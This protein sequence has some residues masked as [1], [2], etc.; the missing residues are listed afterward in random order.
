MAKVARID[1]MLALIPDAGDAGW[2]GTAASDL[3]LRYGLAH[4]VLE[5]V[6]RAAE[7]GD[8]PGMR[9]ALRLRSSQDSLRPIGTAAGPVL[10]AHPDEAS[11][12]DDQQLSRTPVAVV[13]P[14]VCATADERDRR[15]I[16][17]ALAMA[18]EADFGPTVSRNCRVVVLLQRRTM[19]DT[20]VRSW[21]TSALPTTVHLDYFDEHYFV[22]RDLIHEAAHTAMNDLLAAHDVSFPD[23][24]SYYAPWRQ[25]K[26]PAFGFL[27]GVWA[28]SHVALFCARLA[29]AEVPREVAAMARAMYLKHAEE[30]SAA[31]DDADRALQLITEPALADAVRWYRDQ[32]LDLQ[33]S[34][35]GSA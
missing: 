21:T 17:A 27:H 2:A 3:P 7:T 20:D 1:E 12:I 35:A 10:V 26:R 16:Q 11:L 15:L 25:M 30:L 34:M 28:F 23:D 4:H 31:R 18:V 24:A 6:Q 13:D 8:V 14:D 19:H 32:V 22:A 29:E 5:S 9:R 33:S